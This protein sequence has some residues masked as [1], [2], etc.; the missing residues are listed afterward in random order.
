VKIAS[1]PA[2]EYA[3]LIFAYLGEGAP[4][5]F[6]TYP[7]LD[8]PGVLVAGFCRHGDT[9]AERFL[10]FMGAAEFLVQLAELKIG[11]DVSGIVALDGLEFPQRVIVLAEFHIFQCKRVARKRIRRILSEKAL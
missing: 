11:R 2:R 10:G 3:G 5:P 8:R 1:H 6:R 9:A 7:D 4:P